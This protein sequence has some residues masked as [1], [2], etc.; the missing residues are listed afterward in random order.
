MSYANIVKVANDRGSLGRNGTFIQQ[1]NRGML[2][3]LQYATIPMLIETRAIYCKEAENTDIN[4]N[5]FTQNSGIKKRQKKISMFKTW[6]YADVFLSL[7][8][9]FSKKY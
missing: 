6:P 3:D 7:I 4:N 9:S 2:Q 1:Q 5:T 8:E